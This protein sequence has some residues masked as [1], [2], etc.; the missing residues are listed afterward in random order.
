VHIPNLAGKPAPK[1]LLID[2]IRL[3]REY[4]EHR[5]DSGKPTQLVSFGASGHR[6][7]PLQGTHD[8]STNNLINQYRQLKEVL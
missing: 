8:S 4:Y 5:P 3:G 6:G 2:P 1:D 7:S